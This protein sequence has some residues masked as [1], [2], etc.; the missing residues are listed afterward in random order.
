MI[1]PTATATGTPA[2]TAT[3]T[4]TP[5]PTST[6]TGTPAP[7]S[8]TT[9][10]PT[11]TPSS[12]IPGATPEPT[13][14]PTSTLGGTVYMFTYD[15]TVGGDLNAACASY[16]VGGNSSCYSY[17]PT[18]QTGTTLYSTNTG[19]VLSNPFVDGNSKLVVNGT[20]VYALTTVSG[21]ITTIQ[22]CSTPTYTVGQAALG[23]KI[24]YILQS[25]DTGYDVSVQH[26]LVAYPFDSTG[27]WGCN[28]SEMTGADGTAIGTGYQN[29]LDIISGCATAGIAARVC[30][31]LVAGG[32]SDW[33]LPSKD[34]LNTLWGNR[35]DIGG[36]TDSQFYLSSSEVFYDGSYWAWNQYF[37]TG[38]QA[39]ESKATEIRFRPVRSF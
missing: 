18:L 35:Y 5:V 11:P 27:M 8:T 6:S 33:F 25:G 36:F 9:L 21:T 15:G 2:P 31:D 12:T 14:T 28:G 26:G 17:S 30:A 39:N 29:T 20:T 38:Y 19:G 7:T 23:G 3:V 10:T 13:P 34:E 32:Y 1:P 16:P 4:G 24:A 37:L 22:Q